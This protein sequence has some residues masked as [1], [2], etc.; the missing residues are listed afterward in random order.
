VSSAKEKKR[1][2][3]K[4]KKKKKKKKKILS[5]AQMNTGDCRRA[6]RARRARSG[7]A[8]PPASP[9]FVQLART[10]ACGTTVKEVNC[11]V[12]PASKYQVEG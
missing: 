2:K 12:L 1:E 11:P 9:H 3:H 6:G 7:M 10:N 8:Q 5:H 4:R